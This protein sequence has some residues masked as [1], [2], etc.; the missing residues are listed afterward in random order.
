MDLVKPHILHYQTM[1]GSRFSLKLNSGKHQCPDPIVN[2]S[3]LKDL[4]RRA[5][6]LAE[7]PACRWTVRTYAIKKRE[8]KKE[9]YF[10]FVLRSIEEHTCWKSPQTQACFC[11]WRASALAFPVKIYLEGEKKNQFSIL[12]CTHLFFL[13]RYL[14][15]SANMAEASVWRRP[16]FDF[17]H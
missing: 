3:P 8:R 7:N 15:R 6:P 14:L 5:Q 9:N 12:D 4:N 17:G 10:C 11:S 13:P 16:L 1:C 2:F